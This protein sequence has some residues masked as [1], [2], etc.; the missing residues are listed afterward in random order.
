MHTLSFDDFWHPLCGLPL[1]LATCQPA[2]R[3][4][5]YGPYGRPAEFANR[6]MR[7]GEQALGTMCSTESP[8]A[9]RAQA[10]VLLH[11]PTLALCWNNTLR[12]PP[13]RACRWPPAAKAL[14]SLP[15]CQAT[16][17]GSRVGLHLPFE[18][19]H[20]GLDSLE[21]FDASF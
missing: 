19:G 21:L 17:A 9:L 3:T 13:L 5:P 6:P 2:C 1:S 10:Y 15:R 20:F 16:A 8:P 11:A 14:R 4:D 7:V 18:E 12:A